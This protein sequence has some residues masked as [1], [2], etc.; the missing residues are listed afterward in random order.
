MRFGGGTVAA[1]ARYAQADECAGKR[2]WMR[3]IDKHVIEGERILPLN[4]VI[5]GRHESVVRR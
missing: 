1:G 4:Q 2:R 5:G 3:G